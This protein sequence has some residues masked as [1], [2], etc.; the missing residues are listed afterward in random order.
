[1]LT[2]MAGRR[3]PLTDRLVAR[4]FALAIDPAAVSAESA[5]VRRL[6]DADHDALRRALQRVEWRYD[7]RP[8]R[9]PEAAADILRLALSVRTGAPPSATP[10]EI[11]IS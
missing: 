4:A 5:A 10:Q 2:G 7:D 9:I 6:A 11:D 8:S 1:M 3:R